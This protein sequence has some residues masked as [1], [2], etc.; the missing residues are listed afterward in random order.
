MIGRSNYSEAVVVA[1]GAESERGHLP[2]LA[3]DAD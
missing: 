1:T 3:V 2:D